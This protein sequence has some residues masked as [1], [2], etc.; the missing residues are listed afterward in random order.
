MALTRSRFTRDDIADLHASLSLPTAYKHPSVGFPGLGLLLAATESDPRHVFLVAAAAGSLSTLEK[1]LPHVPPSLPLIALLWAGVHNRTSVLVYLL[2]VLHRTRDDWLDEDYLAPLDPTYPS[3]VQAAHLLF[4]DPTLS[5]NLVPAVSSLLNLTHSHSPDNLPDITAVIAD[6]G[7]VEALHTLCEVL[8]FFTSSFP[9]LTLSAPVL[10]ALWDALCDPTSTTP[11]DVTRFA[12]WINSFHL[13]Y[14]SDVPDRKIATTIHSPSLSPST[15]ATLFTSRILPLVAESPESHPAGQLQTLFCKGFVISNVVS[16]ALITP[17]SFS[18]PVLVD[19]DALVGL[20]TLVTLATTSSSEKCPALLIDML[21]TP[22]PANG[23][24]LASLASL[25]FPYASQALSQPSPTGVPLVLGLVI[26]NP[27]LGE[28]I[29]SSPALV[30]SI[31]GFLTSHHCA[32]IHSEISDDDTQPD[33]DPGSLAWEVLIALPVLP[34]V[35]SAATSPLDPDTLAALLTLPSASSSN[36][37]DDFFNSLFRVLYVVQALGRAGLPALLAEAG[38]GAATDGGLASFVPVANALTE[39]L[40]VESFSSLC[41]AHAETQRTLTLLLAYLNAPMHEVSSLSAILALM[42]ECIDLADEVGWGS[43]RRTGRR[44]TKRKVGIPRY[45]PFRPLMDRLGG[46][47]YSTRDEQVRVV[48]RGNSRFRM[49]L[50]CVDFNTHRRCQTV[51]VWVGRVGEDGSELDVRPDEV[52]PVTLVGP[53]FHQ[54]V[55]LV[56]DVVLPECGEGEEAVVFLD[57]TNVGQDKMTPRDTPSPNW[58][59]SAVLIDPPVSSSS[60]TLDTN[61]GASLVD[62]DYVTQ[63]TWRGVYGS[64]GGQLM[65]RHAS[66]QAAFA[67]VE[68][69][70]G[71]PWLDNLVFRPLAVHSYTW[72]SRGYAC[73]DVRALQLSPLPMAISASC[74]HEWDALMKRMAVLKDR[75]HDRNRPQS[76]RPVT[77]DGSGE[78]G[79]LDDAI[80]GLARQ[81]MQRLFDESIAGGDTPVREIT[82][83]LLSLTH[84]SPWSDALQALWR[85]SSR[86]TWQ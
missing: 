63:G 12:T 6:I 55:W 43:T 64:C 41:S 60:S 46:C 65:R 29:A 16:G 45:T 30:D 2:D 61:V 73:G 70:P 18:S 54:G 82:D 51:S 66:D 23:L 76:Q 86:P 72:Q 26:K 78:G 10:L 44:W 42:Q 38:A 62:V 34:H 21:T 37:G 13:S 67:S 1:S 59:L 58:V 5:A 36:V 85:R 19:V 4:D 53:S 81:L 11:D 77:S 27:V 84:D 14:S 24:D 22:H 48:V 15:L 80:D 7:G 56:W 9:A 31:F 47:L 79:G 28:H 40:N 3:L 49:S 83:A 52:E 8:S 69:S 32:T 71:V 57:M 68:R 17:D 75:N 74:D 33:A 35:A 20:D 39:L 25:A 50:Y